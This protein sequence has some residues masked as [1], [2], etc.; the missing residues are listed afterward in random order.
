[1]EVVDLDRKIQIENVCRWGLKN[2]KVLLERGRG[3]VV[4]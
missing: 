3:E 2:L 4:R 1:M